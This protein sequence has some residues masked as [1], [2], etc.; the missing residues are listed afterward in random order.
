MPARVYAL[1]KRNVESEAEVV[2]GTLSIS[3]KLA[4]V[5]IDP[6]ST[7]SF[8]R[9]KFL[10]ALGSKSEILPYVVEVSTPMGE[11]EIKIDKICRKCEVK[12][13]DRIFPADLISLSIHG[14]NVILGMDWLAQY[15]V[16]LNCRTKEITLCI[17]GEPELKLNF[18]KPQRPLELVSGEKSRK[19]LWKGAV[20]YLSYIVN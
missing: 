2:E 19:L 15:Y 3:G 20:G 7:H 5:L 11:Q 16:Q 10:K 9:P 13:G 18:K 4:K 14:Y 1:D 8:V 6:G 17:P 12:I